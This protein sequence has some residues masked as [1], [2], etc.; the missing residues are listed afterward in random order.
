[1]LCCLVRIVISGCV[2]MRAGEHDYVTIGNVLTDADRFLNA[3]RV[4]MEG[5]ANLLA[6]QRRELAAKFLRDRDLPADL[7][8]DE[9]ESTSDA[10]F[11]ELSVAVPIAASVLSTRARVVVLVI[12]GNL[13]LQ[14][15]SQVRC[16]S[17]WTRLRGRAAATERQVYD[18]AAGIPRARLP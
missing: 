8:D 3:K 4:V 7:E 13:H 2:A 9:E 18:R 5:H 11:L 14:L 12:A 10:R 6:D 17:F 16:V 15:S 1:L